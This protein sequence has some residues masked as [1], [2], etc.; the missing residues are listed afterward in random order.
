MEWGH[1]ACGKLL[2]S[3]HIDVLLSREQKFDVLIT[4]LF[5]T[6]CALGLAYKLNISSFIGM[7]SCALM[8]W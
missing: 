1:D 4:E 7:S 3:E 5:N 2:A 6:D 8:P